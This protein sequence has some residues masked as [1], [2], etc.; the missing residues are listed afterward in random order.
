MSIPKMKCHSCLMVSLTDTDNHLAICFLSLSLSITQSLTFV[1]VY[2]RNLKRNQ[3]VCLK[4]A[5]VL[6]EFLGLYLKQRRDKRIISEFLLEMGVT[7]YTILAVVWEYKLG[8]MGLK[9]YMQNIKKG[10]HVY[11][12]ILNL[13][14]IH[15]RS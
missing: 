11:L 7:D 10:N 5:N 8:Q 12:I 15:T 13:V 14:L 4:S 2:N 6:R 9:F 3:L 1:F